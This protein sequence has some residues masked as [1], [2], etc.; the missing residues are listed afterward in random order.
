MVCSSILHISEF[1]F[2]LDFSKTENLLP[3]YHFIPTWCEE[4]K[5]FVF[6][7]GTE[8]KV[9]VEDEHWFLIDIRYTI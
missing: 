5:A 6:P 1:S 9:K 3:A 2:L 8:E 7:Y 4:E